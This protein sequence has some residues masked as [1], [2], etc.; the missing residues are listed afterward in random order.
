[1]AMTVADSFR[2]RSTNRLTRIWETRPGLL[3]CTGHRGSQDDRQTLPRHRVRVPGASA[4]LEAAVMR[5]QLARSDTAPAHARGVQ[6]ALHDARHDDDLLVRLA[7][8]LGI[9]Q[10][11]L[12][13]ACSARATWPSP[14]SMRFSYWVFLVSGLFLYSSFLIGQAPDGGWFAYVPLTTHGVLARPQHGLLRAGPDVPRRLHDRR[15][16]QLHRRRSS[17]CARRACRSTA[18]R[19]SCGER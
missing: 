15:G 7:G 18:C 2:P 6:P 1:M 10:L 16:D 13:A 14:G 4:G 19:S 3:G 12:A 17:R 5:L 8:A 9:Q 11:P